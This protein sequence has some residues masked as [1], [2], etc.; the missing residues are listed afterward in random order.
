MRPASLSMSACSA[1]VDVQMEIA[2]SPAAHDL[3]CA[4]LH[5]SHACVCVPVL[6]AGDKQWHLFIASDTS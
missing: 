4:S 3:L 5:A 6:T 1:I 2:N